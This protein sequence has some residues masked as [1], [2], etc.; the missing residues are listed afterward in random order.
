ML[1]LKKSSAID[2]RAL[3]LRGMDEHG[4]LRMG[5]HK[6]LKMG[7]H[8][9]LIQYEHGVPNIEEEKARQLL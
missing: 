9:V 3:P 5:E 1:L 8:G 6:V 7:E 4:V 2:V